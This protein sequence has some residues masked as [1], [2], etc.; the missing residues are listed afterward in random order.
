MRRNKSISYIKK[1]EKMDTVYDANEALNKVREDSSNLSLCFDE[2]KKYKEVVLEV[3][4]N[5]GEALEYVNE[6]LNKIKKLC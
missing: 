6:L 2:I 4:N 3:V 1:M 5:D